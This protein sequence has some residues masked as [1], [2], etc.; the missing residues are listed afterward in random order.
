MNLQEDQQRLAEIEANNQQIEGEF[1]PAWKTYKQTQH[2]EI[3]FNQYLQ[4]HDQANKDYTSF[5]QTNGVT[6]IC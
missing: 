4:T 1:G 6:R 3:S 2:Q 5:I